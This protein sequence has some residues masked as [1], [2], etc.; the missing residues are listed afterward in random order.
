MTVLL[1]AMSTDLVLLPQIILDNS[2]VANHAE[3][4]DEIRELCSDIK[5]LGKPAL[6]YVA[7][8][9]FIYF[10]DLDVSMSLPT[11]YGFIHG[12]MRCLESY[13]DF[14]HNF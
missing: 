14:F 9:N 8:Y 12:F 13:I 11:F 6:K 1:D 7:V 4:T 5:V 10:C 3:T 2:D